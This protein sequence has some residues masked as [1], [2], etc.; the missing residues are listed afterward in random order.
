MTDY[1]QGCCNLESSETELEE[2][3]YTTFV[4]E[5]QQNVGDIKNDMLDKFINFLNNNFFLELAFI[6]EIRKLSKKYKLIRTKFQ[7]DI[8]KNNIMNILRNSL[9]FEEQ[10]SSISNYLDELSYKTILSD[11]NNSN[12]FIEFNEIALFGSK[13]LF[14]EFRSKFDYSKKDLLDLQ[15]EITLKLKSEIVGLII[16]LILDSNKE[17]LYYIPIIKNVINDKTKDNV[18]KRQNLIHIINSPFFKILQMFD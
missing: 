16:D 17:C 14:A 18:S 6:Q 1:Q 3:A 7:S 2:S 8:L 10:F 15:K 5:F 4:N 13:F 12:I 9:G 11:D